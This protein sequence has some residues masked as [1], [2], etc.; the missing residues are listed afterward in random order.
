MI[1]ECNIYTSQ[2]YCEGNF[3]TICDPLVGIE[4]MAVQFRCNVLPSELRGNYCQIRSKNAVHSW[5]YPFIA[6]VKLIFRW[7]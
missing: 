2:K 3:A 1:A 7:I 5:N 6:I 4:S